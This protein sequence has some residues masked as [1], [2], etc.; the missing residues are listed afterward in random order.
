M[1]QGIW[2]HLHGLDIDL[3]RFVKVLLRFM[4]RIPERQTENSE[5][6]PRFPEILLKKELCFLFILGHC[7]VNTERLTCLKTG[8]AP[9]ELACVFTCPPPGHMS[10]ASSSSPPVSISSG[11]M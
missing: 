9:R 10:S 1:S 4:M 5:I 3:T 7:D 8:N 2:A 6:G 11:F